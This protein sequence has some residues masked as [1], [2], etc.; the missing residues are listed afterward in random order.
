M[1]ETIPQV[2]QMAPD[3]SVV[4]T[5]GRELVFSQVLQT[6]NSTVLVFYRGHW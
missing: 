2:G 4:A 3:F 1:T 5:N 6:Q